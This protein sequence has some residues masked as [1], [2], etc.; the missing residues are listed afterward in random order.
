MELSR[1]GAIAIS[2]S[3]LEPFTGNSSLLVVKAPFRGP[4]S[5]QKFFWTGLCD[6]EG[7]V[8]AY[9]KFE[10]RLFMKSESLFAATELRLASSEGP[11]PEP[12]LQLSG[13][14]KLG[15]T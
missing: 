14:Q 11:R 15:G 1:M 5:A 3:S 7:A 4:P 9:I 10:R 12:F 8:L 6:S 13:C 2:H